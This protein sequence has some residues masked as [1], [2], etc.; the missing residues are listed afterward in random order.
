MGETHNLWITVALWLVPLAGP[1]GWFPLAGSLWLVHG[2][3]TT[4]E[5]APSCGELARLLS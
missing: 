4:L 5:E 2:R 1:F 3:N